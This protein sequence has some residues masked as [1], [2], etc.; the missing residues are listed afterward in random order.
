ML[1]LQGLRAQAAVKCSNK[2]PGSLGARLS[3]W[4]ARSAWVFVSFKLDIIHLLCE[5]DQ[6]DTSFDLSLCTLSL[7]GSPAC[8]LCQL[9]R[10]HAL[11]RRSLSLDL[12]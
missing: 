4:G 3:P 2:Q 5:H 6:C 12:T 8:Q 10:G 11:R 1:A 7:S 9:S